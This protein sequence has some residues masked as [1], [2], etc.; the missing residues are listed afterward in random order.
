MARREKTYL[1]IDL[2][3]TNLHFVLVNLRGKILKEKVIPTPQKSEEAIKEIVFQ[4]SQFNKDVI[5]GVGLAIAGLVNQKK[6]L[7]HFSP[8][9]GWR[10]IQIVKKIKKHYPDL[11][12]VLENDANA[13]AWGAYFLYGKKKIKNLIC[14]T[15]GTGL[16]GGIIINGEIYRGAEGTA[17]EIGHIT[18]YPQG[19]RCNCGN[20]GCIERYIGAKHLV[21]R[22][23]KE[24][25][26]GKKSI[27][28]KLV[29]DDLKKITPEIITRAAEKNDDLAK[30]IWDKMGE[31]LGI[32]LSGV[33][34]LLNPEMVILTG[35]ISKAAK[36]FFSKLNNQLKKSTLCDAYKKTKIVVGKE[37]L[38][39]IGAALLA[40]EY[41]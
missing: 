34:N 30:K 22:A 18:L 38:G 35:G 41:N 29:N 4:I 28:K 25:M 33:I 36:F 3:A 6:G 39:V 2:G 23:Q 20:Y 27:I 40:K 15:L 26:A 5:K 8:N 12:V 16:G 19:L 9:L 14:L 21:E 32:T 24:I 31:N 13:A 10:N 17:G 7:I 1:G 37:N 11:K